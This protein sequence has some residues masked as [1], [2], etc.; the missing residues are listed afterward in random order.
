MPSFPPVNI[1]RP[2]AGAAVGEPVVVRP[3]YFDA[4]VPG[5]ETDK[6]AKVSNV[7][8]GIPPGA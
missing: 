4:I 5:V 1:Y 7:I 3:T 6:F 8:R 2:L